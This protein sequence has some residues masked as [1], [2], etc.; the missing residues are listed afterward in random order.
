MNFHWNGGGWGRV[1]YR[2]AYARSG[3]SFIY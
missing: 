3:V 1:S 2:F